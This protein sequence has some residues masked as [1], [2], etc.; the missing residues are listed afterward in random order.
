[1]IFRSL[2]KFLKLDLLDLRRGELD[3]H[4]ISLAGKALIRCGWAADLNL[5]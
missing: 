2:D 1:M 3:R 4:K 5:V